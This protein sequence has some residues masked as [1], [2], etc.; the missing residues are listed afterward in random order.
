MLGLRMRALLQKHWK[1]NFVSLMFEQN[2]S[3]YE[4]IL[5]L[6]SLDSLQIK[7][8]SSSVPAFNNHF[9]FI[10]ITE[11]GPSLQKDFVLEWI[12]Q[13]RPPP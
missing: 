12:L 4:S 10:F 8:P 1:G 9:P 5:S 7:Y 2:Y 13:L 3:K 6:Y 11:M